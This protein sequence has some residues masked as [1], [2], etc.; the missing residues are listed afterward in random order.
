MAG[1]VRI[2]LDIGSSAVRV[3]EVTMHGPN[4][5]LT[6]FGQVGLPEGAVVEGEVRDHVAV[7][8]AI[9]RLWSEA[10]IR[11]RDVVIG[12]SSQRSLVRLVE[13]PKMAGSELRSALQYQMA[14]LLPIGVEQAIFD[15]V[16]LGPGKPSGD[17]GE[18]VQVLLVVAQREIVVDHIK[19]VKRAGL[20]VRAVDSSP[21]ALLRA[22]PGPDGGGLEA[23][24]SLGAQLV[25]VAVRQGLV[26]RFVRTVGRPG[27]SVAAPVED[28]AMVGAGTKGVGGSV[29]SR[30]SAPM[31]D[32][33][34]EEVRGS[35]E[36][37]HSH[38][39][40]EKLGSVVLTG[41]GALAEGMAGRLAMALA[42]PVR[43]GEVALRYDPG[44]LELRPA[45]VDEARLR[46]A[47]VVGLALWGLAEGPAPSLVPEEVRHQEQ[48][49]RALAASAAGL[50][51]V[52][53]GLG[54]VSHERVD[55]ANRVAR[56]VRTENAE[57]ASL[58]SRILALHPLT[59]VQSDLQ[60]RRT[61]AQEAL[62]GD[63]NWVGLVGR[64]TKALPPGVRITTMN[65]S[66]SAVG[67]VATAPASGQGANEDL[68]Q[69]T[70]S[71]TANGGAPLVAEFVRKMWD[72]RGIY[73]LWVS[74]T[75][76]AGTG[77]GQVTTFSA[78]AQVTG[79]ALS[80]R[81][82]KLPGGGK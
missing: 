18:T 70:M 38:F 21:L 5:E 35:L 48:F 44:K 69:V 32:P 12:V 53:A 80:G 8:K 49:R 75:A 42:V 23:V 1:R 77:A 19:V 34:V 24:V 63:I 14:E 68:G 76:T 43:L 4:G 17:G 65:L 60:S 2:G 61:L 62:D 20:R 26:P 33:M 7:A 22:L 73:A 59:V 82:E 64:I 15:Y 56:G 36:Y 9:K 10:G 16:E 27:D 78:T 30:G 74:G 55:A 50:V 3:A 25:V 37:F 54:V 58:Q 6:R 57:A 45:Q 47:P 41:G 40:D 29:G 28:G 81:S 66:R 79:A 71:L 51:V 52:A 67:A 31:L 11:R 46:W 72:V 39:Q 13:M